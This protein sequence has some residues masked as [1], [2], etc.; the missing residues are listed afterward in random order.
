MNRKTFLLAILALVL[1][2]FVAGVWFVSRPDPTP[3]ATA[4]PLEQQDRLVRSYSP[5]LGREDAPVTIVEFF[6]PACEACRAFHPIV[7][8][9]LAQY[10]DDVRV[11]MRYTPFHGEGSELA[12]KVLEAARLQDVFVPVLEALLENQPAWAS[13]GAPAAE[14]IME[15]AGAAGLD[16]DAAANQIMSPSIVGV[17]NQDRADVEDVGIQST[18][19]FFVNSKPLSEFG[20]E[21]LLS[22]VQSEVE[23][24]AT[25]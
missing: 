17:L 9:I 20:A 25:N 21:Q 5:V 13:H 23:A 10:P 11:V 15:I 22:L 16:T 3:V 6:D 7:K 18:P 2:V 4:A 1:A 12:I 19:T 14:R 8:Q 24:A